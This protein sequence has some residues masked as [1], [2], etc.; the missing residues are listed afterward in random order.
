MI[1]PRDIGYEETLLPLLTD[2]AEAAAYLDAVLEMEDPAALLV[3]LR[4]V[5]KAHGMAEVARRADVGD[6]TLFRAL[7]ENGN[8]TLD[9][10]TKVLHA[11]GL[12]LSV[13]PLAA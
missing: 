10:V 11:V 7:S 3:A 12:R 13:A 1:A 4:Q 8:P 6:K 2:P 9:T 5:A